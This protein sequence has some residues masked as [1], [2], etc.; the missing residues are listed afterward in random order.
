METGDMLLLNFET[1]TCIDE[2]Y[3]DLSGGKRLKNIIQ[4][5]SSE[6]MRNV[7]RQPTTQKHKI[8]DER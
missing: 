3:D 6:G 4:N 2:I 1:K 8:N 5:D 7:I